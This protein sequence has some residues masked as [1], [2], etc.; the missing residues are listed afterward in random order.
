[1]QGGLDVKL[2]CYSSAQADIWA[3]GVILL[4]L[5]TGGE[6]AWKSAKYSDN[7]FFHYI[8]N[9]PDYLA[10]LY[11]LSQEVNDILKCIFTTNPRNRILLSELRVRIVSL[12]AFQGDLERFWHELDGIE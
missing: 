4:N 7:F 12:E 6:F 3:L 9:E 1:M 10:V 11:P 8:M 5:V 2:R